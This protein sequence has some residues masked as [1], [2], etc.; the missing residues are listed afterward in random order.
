[1]TIPNLLKKPIF[2]LL[3]YLSCIF[4]DTFKSIHME[5]KLPKNCFPLEITHFSSFSVTRKDS[6]Y[7]YILEDS[8]LEIQY[9]STQD[10]KLLD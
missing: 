9:F 7:I 3:A 5:L 8:E 10:S 4:I 1:M 6:F 2:C